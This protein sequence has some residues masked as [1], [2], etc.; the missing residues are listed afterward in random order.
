MFKRYSIHSK[1]V[2]LSIVS[3]VLILAYAIKLSLYELEQYES[4][5]RS[6]NVV[7]LSIYLSNVLHESQKERG[8]SAGYLGSKGNK[9]TQKLPQ[10][11]LL[12]D[13]KLTLL[14]NHI[15]SV[16]NQFTRA[17]SN[18]IDFS[19]MLSMRSS[20]DN[21]SV[22]TKAAVSYYTA[23]NKSIL[24][25]ITEFSTLSRD[26][27]IRNMLNSLVLFISAKER[28]GI[29]RAILSATFARDEFTPFLNSKFLSVMAQQNALFNLFEY[30]ANE[31]FK[32]SYLT[33]KVDSSFAEVQRMRDLALSKKKGFETD[34]GYWFKTITQKINKLKKME[35]I[36]TSSVITT[37]Q[38]IKSSSLWMLIVVFV[39]SVLALLM[40]F[41]L[42]RGINSVI[43]TK[44]ENFKTLLEQVKDGDL[45]AQFSVSKTSKN[46]MDQIGLQFQSLVTI[47][48]D[49]T[50][51][52]TTSVHFAS[53]GDF[54]SCELKDEGFSGEFATAI[55]SVQSGI[56]AMKDA[57]D[58]QELIRFT[59][60]LRKINNIGG[61]ISFIQSEISAL[62][63]DL[64]DVLK[65]TDETSSQSEESLVVVDEILSKL[66]TLVVNINDSNAT[67]EGLDE[68]SN[69][70]TS[71]VDLIKTI[72]EQ[73]NLL[74][75][76]AAIEAARAGEHG[77]GF[78]VVADEVRN[79]AEHTQKATDE[80]AVSIGGMRKETSSI[81]EKSAVMTELANA[82][83]ASVEN[84]KETMGHLSSDTKEMSILVE[85]MGNQSFIVLAK[86]DH[87]IFKS[88]AYNSMIDAD[89]S[90]QFADH[91]NCR[92]GKWY[93]TTAKEKFSKLESYPKINA[94][95]SAV[96]NCV[97]ANKKFIVDADN[98]LANEK[99]ITGNYQKMEQ[100][101]DELFSLLDS[102]REE[103]SKRL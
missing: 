42:S 56:S 54:D 44:I 21:Q 80:I 62:V 37:A 89:A 95:H 5:K 19:K 39:I 7:E 98:R 101:S 28:A 88:N 60:E 59:A 3:M 20:V 15:S 71:V 61:S 81:V 97:E 86:I 32:K 70:I 79:L 24:D 63:D 46:E 1:L 103:S 78:S 30:S 22:D 33:I 2:I 18:N 66:K 35:D 17:A 67:I 11:R 26:P 4:S 91:K 87:V 27:Q 102:L 29:E 90:V 55:Q 68:R 53:K 14:K 65:T 69:D 13:E 99:L 96:H 47:M 100:A 34:P 74:A 8:A 93:G 94:P 92:L 9:F 36:I 64:A 10:Q 77:R 31:Q 51:Q 52:I 58:K 45:S 85:D 84:F 83:S 76:N 72:A 50:T 38:E 40:T 49:L 48:Q 25:T 73:T 16:D 43:M 6:I 23:L 41:F 82:V 75:L 57:H 12:T